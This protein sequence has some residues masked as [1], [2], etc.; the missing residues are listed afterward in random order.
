MSCIMARDLEIEWSD[1]SPSLGTQL[2]KFKVFVP[3]LIVNKCE[4]HRK[5]LICLYG[6]DLISAEARDEARAKLLEILK[7]NVIA[8]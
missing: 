6:D 7:R 1:H 5:R 4:L 3:E 2:K 8:K